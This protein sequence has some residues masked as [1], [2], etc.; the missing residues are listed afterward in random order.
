MKN[1]SRNLNVILT[2][3]LAF[4]LILTWLGPFVIKLL[5]TPPVSFGVNCEPAAAFAMNKLI[6]TQT[7]GLVAGG[8]SSAIFLATRGSKKNAPAAEAPAK[9]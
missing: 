6:W 1:I 4:A 2:T 7:I 5:F 8:L 9:A 3:A